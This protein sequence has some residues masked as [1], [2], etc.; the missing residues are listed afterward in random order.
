MLF[1]LT[2]KQRN[3]VSGLEQSSSRS[4]LV[5][6]KRYEPNRTIYNK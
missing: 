1:K 5:K 6:N 3:K 2:R 4:F